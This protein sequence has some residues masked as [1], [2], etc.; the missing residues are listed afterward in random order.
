MTFKNPSFRDRARQAADAKDKALKQLRLRPQPDQSV[1]DQRKAAGARREGA[2]AE[3]AA[4]KKAAAEAAVEARAKA[5]ARPLRPL[6]RTRRGR[7]HE[8]HV[9]LR[10]RLA[11]KCCD[12]GGAVRVSAFHPKLPLA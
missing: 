6:L 2:Q 4:A 1:V 7:Q 5:R 12:G 8:M 11:D 3:K 10:G 9:M